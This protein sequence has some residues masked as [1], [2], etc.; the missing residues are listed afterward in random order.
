MAAS[1]TIKFGGLVKSQICSPCEHFGRTQDE[2]F[3][4]PPLLPKMLDVVRKRLLV[5]SSDFNPCRSQAFRYPDQDLT[6]VD[7]G[8]I[9][10]AEYGESDR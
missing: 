8:S 4:K 5:V 1:T 6:V 10:F 2:A 9:V 3:E 7:A